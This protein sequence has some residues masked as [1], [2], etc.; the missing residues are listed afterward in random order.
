MNFFRIDVLI[1]RILRYNKKIVWSIVLKF[2]EID[3]IIFL[4][5]N[6]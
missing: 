6:Y 1:E 3:G 5:E 2:K 4:F